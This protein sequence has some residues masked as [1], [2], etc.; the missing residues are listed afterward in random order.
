MTLLIAVALLLFALFVIW[1]TKYR[2]PPPD[3]PQTLCYHKLSNEFC[4]E[5]TWMP[6]GRFLDQIDHLQEH[7]YR[8]IDEDEFIRAVSNPEP[9]NAARIFLTFD[10]GYDSLYA[11]YTEELERRRVPMHV[12]IPTDYA[13]RDNDWDLGLGRPPFRHLDWDEVMDLS[14]RGVSF[15][16][17]GASHVDLTTLKA[18]ALKREIEDSKAT[19]EARLQKPVRSF[20]YPFGR[21]SDEARALVRAAGYEVAFSLYPPRSNEDVDLLALRRNGVYIIDTSLSI[22]CKLTRNPF[23]WFEEMKC[24]TINRVAVLTPMFKRSSAGPDR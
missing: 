18:D 5:G 13:G 24:R 10:D 4:F 23:F 21:Y 22:Q 20:S 6:P 8:F 3:I 17:H 12:F 2:Y 11:V 19:I 14:Q 7:G 15:G 1:R 16:S 9:K